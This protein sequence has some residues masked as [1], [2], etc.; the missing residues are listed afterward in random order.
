[1]IGV[2]MKSASIDELNAIQ[3]LNRLHQADGS[4]G[5]AALSSPHPG[6]SLARPAVIRR[7]GDMVDVRNRGAFKIV[8]LVGAQRLGHTPAVV[9]IW[10]GE[11]CRELSV[12]DARCLAAQLL[13]AAAYAEEQNGM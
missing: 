1:M 9:R 10:N 8:N 5:H 13:E 12:H 6:A 11:D 3:E 2:A 7:F 4:H